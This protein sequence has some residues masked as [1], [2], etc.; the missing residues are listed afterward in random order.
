MSFLCHLMQAVTGTSYRFWF[1][2]GLLLLAPLTKAQEPSTKSASCER[3]IE[4]QQWIV[5]PPL[6]VSEAKTLAPSDIAREC[7][8]GYL[9]HQPD[10]WGMTFEKSPTLRFHF[11]NRALPW[12]SLK[13]H[14]VDGFDNNARN[15]GA[16]ALLHA[17]FGAEKQNDPAE[18]G[19]M[20]YL[21]GCTDPES[22]FAYSPD[23]LPRE[24]PLGEGE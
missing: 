14:G 12:P 17:V 20:F 4:T 18:A 23:A 13:H 6:F 9:S 21:L 2:V 10:P 5:L 8:K 24:C 3:R 11:D 1:A 22:G 16:H 15:V 7:W 19:Q